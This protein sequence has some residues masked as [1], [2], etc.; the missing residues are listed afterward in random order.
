MQ[1]TWQ[2]EVSQYTFAANINLL[3]CN[4]FFGVRFV[5]LQSLF[6]QSGAYNDDAAQ[7]IG[8]LQQFVT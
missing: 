7:T 3:N 2:C 6:T 1:W 5:F 8:L 4:H